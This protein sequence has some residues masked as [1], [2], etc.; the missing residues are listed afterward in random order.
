MAAGLPELALDT[1]YHLIYGLTVAAVYAAAA[2]RGLLGPR[3]RAP[4]RVMG[5]CG[6]FLLLGGLLSIT[7]LPATPCVLLGDRGAAFERLARPGEDRR[8]PVVALHRVAARV[9]SGRPSCSLLIHLFDSGTPPCCSLPM[10]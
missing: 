10:R 5:T 6:R 8:E 9:L 4:G 7:T 2:S 3:L 1:S